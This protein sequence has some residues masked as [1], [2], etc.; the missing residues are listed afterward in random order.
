MSKKRVREEEFN[1]DEHDAMMEDYKQSKKMVTEEEAI[2]H[3]EHQFLRDDEA[4]AAA[5]EKNWRVRMAMRYYKKLFKEYALGDFSRY[6]EGKVGLRWCTEAEVIAGKGQFVCGNKQCDAVDE[7][8]SYE[9]LFAYAE[10]GKK[11]E[12]LVKLRVCPS[13]ATKLFYK[14]TK[15][16]KHHKR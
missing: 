11:K 12:C 1:R 6:K 8:N 16:H 5:G 9:V 2:L 14:K 3:E 7:L 13:C 4:D 10:Q 15:K